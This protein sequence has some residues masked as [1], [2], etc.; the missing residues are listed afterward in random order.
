MRETR[1]SKKE[2]GSLDCRSCVIIAQPCPTGIE[3]GSP[4]LKAE[5]LLSE[6]PQKTQ[7]VGAS[8]D[9]KIVETEVL[10]GMSSNA[11]KMRN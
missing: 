6:P 2:V 7:T 11:S 4:V 5:C 10:E 3:F 1:D 8:G 9:K